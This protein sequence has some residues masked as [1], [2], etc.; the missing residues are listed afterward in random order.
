MTA[1]VWMNAVIGDFGRAAG[2]NGHLPAVL[3]VV[4]R[5]PVSPPELPGDAPVL[6][7]LQPVAVGV[8]K[9]IGVELD[10][11]VLNHLEGLLGQIGHTQEPLGT[12]LRLYHCVGTLRVTHLVGIV[13]YLLHQTGFLKVFHYRLAASEAVHTG[14][15]HAFVVERAVVVED[16]D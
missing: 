5:D 12:Q 11:V 10:C 6:D 2:L 8:L 13:L 1:P 16:I 4:S 15:L 3:A 14:I 9:F 7:I